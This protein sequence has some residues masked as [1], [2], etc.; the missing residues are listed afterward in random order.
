MARAIVLHC[1]ALY[2]VILSC[3]VDCYEGPKVDAVGIGMVLLKHLVRKEVAASGGVGSS[4]WEGRWDWMG[5]WRDVW[6]GGPAG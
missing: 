2:C 5:D 6:G 4:S 3:L 1:L